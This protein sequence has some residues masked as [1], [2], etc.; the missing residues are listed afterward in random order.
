MHKIFL[1]PLWH[2][3]IQTPNFPEKTLFREFLSRPYELLKQVEEEGAKLLGGKGEFKLTDKIIDGKV[4]ATQGVIA[5]CAG[6]MYE[7]VAE[8]SN[9][10]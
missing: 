10:H 5:G 2:L 3:S 6:G 4:Y 1:H 9:M 7:N 8:A